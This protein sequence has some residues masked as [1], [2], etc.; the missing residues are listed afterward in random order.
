MAEVQEVP[1]AILRRRTHTLVYRASE[2]DAAGYAELERQLTVREKDASGASWVTFRA[3]LKDVDPHG[4]E[5]YKAAVD[6]R[7][8]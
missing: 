5:A 2:R 4:R 1:R 8:I 3:I 7:L 6:R